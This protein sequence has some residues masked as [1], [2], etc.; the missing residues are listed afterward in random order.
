MATD[1]QFSSGW[2]GSHLW[3]YAVNNSNKVWHLEVTFEKLVNLKLGKKHRAMPDVIKFV[4]QP[5]QKATAYAKRT[6]PGAVA[7]AWSFAQRLE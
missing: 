1:C 2:S 5:Y 6:S 4:I 7:V 3:M